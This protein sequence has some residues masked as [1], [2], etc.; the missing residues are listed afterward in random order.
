MTPEIRSHKG[1][2]RLIKFD[3]AYELVMSAA[4]QLEVGILHAKTRSAGKTWGP[5]GNHNQAG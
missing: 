5:A 1:H 2:C 3:Y 4:V